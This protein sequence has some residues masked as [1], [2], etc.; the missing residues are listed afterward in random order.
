MTSLPPPRSPFA[1]LDIPTMDAILVQIETDF[2]IPH[3][4]RQDMCSAIRALSKLFERP[5]SMIP[6]SPDFLRRVNHGVAT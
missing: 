3:Q 5:L 4:R 2:Q 1:D 6:A